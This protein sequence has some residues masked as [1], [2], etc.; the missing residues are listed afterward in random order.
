MRR[1]GSSLNSV[2][3]G[4]SFLKPLPKNQIISQ[5]RLTSFPGP[6][7]ETHSKSAWPS[8]ATSDTDFQKSNSLSF[9][10]FAAMATDTPSTPMEKSPAPNPHG[11]RPGSHQRSHQGK[12]RQAKKIRKRE[13]AMQSGSTEQVL[14]FDIRDLRASL[15]GVEADDVEST[16]TTAEE[17][18]L[19]E[20]DSEI[21]L[22]VVELSSTGDALAVQKD[23][24][25][26]QIYV[27][28]FA[29]PGDTVK[30]KVYRHLR[31]EGYTVADFISVVSPAPIRDDTRVRCP[32]FS[33]CSG[34]QFQMLDYADQLAHKKKIVERAFANFSELPPELLPTIGDTIGSP[35]Q[36]GYRTKLTPHF[37]GPPGP[38][39]NNTATFTKRPDVGFMFKGKRA[40]LDIEDCPIGTDVVRQGMKSERERMDREFAKY[41]KGATIL[42]RESTKRVPKDSE[43]TSSANTEESSSSPLVKV[44]TEKHVDWKTC[45]TDNNGTSTEYI[46]D[47]VFHNPAGSFFQNNNSIL[48]IFTE[49]IRQHILPPP[50]SSSSP[51]KYLIDAYS[52]S[53]LFTITL[54]SLFQ[55]STGIDIAESSIAFARTNAAANNLPT[56]Q[57]NF[58]AADAGELFKSVTYP[59]DETVVVLDP[60]R[61]GCDGDFLRQ[62]LNFAPRRVVYVSCNVHTQARDIGVLV[63]GDDDGG[64]GARYAVESL[65]GFD[66][67]PQTGHVE[68]VAVLNRVDEEQGQ[69]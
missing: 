28:P 29:V 53:G 6:I 67:F 9:K 4:Y 14:A 46:G 58:I 60:P 23:S 47:Y 40:T 62:L 37:D 63:R 44:E 2:V 49:Y 13:R 31:N 26:K 18:P 39:R 34:C 65:R 25:S 30:A 16:T 36:Y 11:K 20:P 45:V 61:K 69:E 7:R 22:N 17:E 35:L 1:F 52:G 3:R 27:L 54:S 12:K 48:P 5:S 51:I 24:S 15:T 50:S 68:G 43:T 64:K 41:K 59:A 38:R 19:P 57:A 8:R 66:F 42:L 10:E 56:S 32:Y 33:K 55:G 21:L